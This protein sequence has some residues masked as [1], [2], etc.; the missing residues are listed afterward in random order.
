[1]SGECTV[2]VRFHKPSPALS[3]YFTS[4][5][6]TRID[7]AGGGRVEDL[8][9]PEWAG[10]RMIRGATSETQQLGREVV[11]GIANVAMAPTANSVRF[12]IGSSRIWGIGLL[13]AGWAKFVGMPA[14]RLVGEVHD[15]TTHPAYSRVRGLVAATYAGE[16]DEAA[17]LAR[18]DRFFLD[19]LREPSPD[20]ERI[21][22][23][24]SALI[25]PDV[26]TVHDMVDACRIKPHTLE[27][28]CRR[29]FGFAPSLLLRRQRFMRSLAEY[30]LD[31]SLRWIG[32]I[33]A[34]YH[35]QAQFVRD[36]HRFMGMSPSEYAARPHP[37]L[38][39]VMHARAAAAG[40]AVQALHPP[41]AAA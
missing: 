38:D 25:D 27:R 20:E 1:M 6:L 5:Y 13:P 30:M 24:H 28:L 22:A 18:I 8:L 9:H 2:Q 10:I 31:P 35:D 32:A 23:I 7:V 26:G 40:A 29:H 39:A 37:I 11:S 34:H 14:N 33:D 21:V 15:M 36:F 19:L 3:R 12:T 16:S 4:F 41:T 17:E